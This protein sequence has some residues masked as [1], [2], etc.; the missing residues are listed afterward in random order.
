M[1][2]VLT[3]VFNNAQECSMFQSVRLPSDTDA[4]DLK[5]NL[6]TVRCLGVGEI[7]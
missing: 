6:I 1:V 7:S 3:I 5:G 4:R 2:I